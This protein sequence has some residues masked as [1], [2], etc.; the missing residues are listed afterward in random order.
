[1]H[2]ISDIRQIEVHVAESLLHDFSTLKIEIAIAKLKKHESPLI[3]TEG[4][5]LLYGI[6]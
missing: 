1:L 5:T 2:N 4:D 3:Q 6:K